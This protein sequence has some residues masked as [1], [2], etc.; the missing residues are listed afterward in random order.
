M[1]IMPHPYNQNLRSVQMFYPNYNGGFTLIELSV[2]LLIMGLIAI[3]VATGLSMATNTRLNNIMHRFATYQA[4][5]HSFEQQYQQLPGDISN[6][7]NFWGSDCHA[8]ASYCNGDGDQV[9]ESL[10]SDENNEAYRAWLHLSLAE[11]IDGSFTGDGAASGNG[12][13]AD[14]GNNMPAADNFFSSSDGG[15]VGYWIDNEAEPLG[16]VINLGGEY[17]ENNEANFASLSPVDAY[18]LDHKF[19]D[20]ISDTGRFFARDSVGDS[21]DC[22]SGTTSGTY[23]IT[24]TSPACLIRVPIR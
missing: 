5:I 11:M 23:N 18:Y 24:T 8:T 19:D 13:G 10:A 1:Q 16:N 17:D 21:G 3:T 9:I 15:N 4:V 12:I 20:S 6:A 2:V 14:I 22:V 7:Y